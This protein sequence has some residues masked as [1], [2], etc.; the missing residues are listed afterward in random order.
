VT[1][2]QKAEYDQMGPWP[3]E[4]H[5]KHRYDMVTEYVTIMKELWEKGQS[6]FKGKF[7]TMND[8]RLGPLPSHPIRLISAGT[9]DADGGSLEDRARRVYISNT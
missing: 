2:W 8:C 9:S 4:E 3:G 6:D 1:V 5:F 7:F